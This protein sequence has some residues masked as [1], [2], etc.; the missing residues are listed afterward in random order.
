MKKY[1]VAIAGC[2]PRGV[3]HAEAFLE[4]GDRFELTAI[5]DM[6]GARM[7]AVAQKL[8]V[9]L[10]CYDNTEMMLAEERP[11]VFCFCTQPNT[12]LELVEMGIRYGV[13]AIA[14]E[15]PMANDLATAKRMRD[16]LRKANVFSIQ[17]HQHKY[18]A[19]WRKVKQLVDTS[20]IG[21]V[22]TI[23]V[24]AKGWFLHYA[25]HLLDYA[26]WLTG[27]THGKW[28]IGHAHGREK[29]TDIH[30]SPD[31]VEGL[32]EFDNG[33]RCFLECGTLA[34]HYPYEDLGFWM[35]AGA[36]VYG[37]DG[38]AQV[39]VGK[40]WRAA[41]KSSSGMISG[42]GG[43]DPKLDQPPY[44]KDLAA[45]LDDPTRVHPCNG[46]VSYNGF[47]LANGIL[48]SALEH[49]KVTFPLEASETPIM[50][51]FLKVLPA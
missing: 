24:T 8:P 27:N 25:T 43:F 46:E 48:V 23:H 10:H 37:T 14:Y 41:T 45:W 2:G 9:K 51:R 28:A 4:N 12:R 40:G 44:I 13:K 6:D 39:I 20:E 42:A 11:D 31:Y 3:S 30:P 38:Y 29:L 32:V 34:P 21:A 36:T 19:H 16:A 49:R 7:A 22:H 35:D 1:R 33:V 50:E 5:S 17:S 26:M 47:E 15:K 18:G